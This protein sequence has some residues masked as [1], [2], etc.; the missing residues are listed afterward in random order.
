MHICITCRFDYCNALSGLPKKARNKLQI[1][2][3]QNAA[4]HVLT[5]TRWR[6]PISPVLESL[7]GYPSILVISS[8]VGRFLK[9]LN[10]LVAAWGDGIQCLWPSPLEQPDDITICER[11]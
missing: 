6:A 11:L 1:I 5:E 8:K 2:A 4:A 9:T 10:G 3:F 7:I